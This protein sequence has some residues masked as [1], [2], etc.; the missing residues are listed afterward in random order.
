LKNGNDG[1]RPEYL[2]E[3]GGGKAIF[4]NKLLFDP[5]KHKKY[6]AQVYFYHP[7][8]NFSELLHMKV[9]LLL[10]ELENQ[11]KYS[12]NWAQ[13]P[14]GS[15]QSKR[16]YQ[17]YLDGLEMIGQQEYPN[18]LRPSSPDGDDER[19]ED[20][21]FPLKEFNNKAKLL[22]AAEWERQLTIRKHA[23]QGEFFSRPLPPP[24]PLP[25]PT[26]PPDR[27]CTAAARSRDC[28]TAHGRR[29]QDKHSILQD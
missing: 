21:T 11:L 27:P 16:A 8:N 28:G 18:P 25:L 9:C 1:V 2:D 14:P 13:D 12:S 24:P 3:G 7:P 6:N 23:L 10:H 22:E 17:D 29:P 15:N 5:E 19:A 20:S 26:P 4:R